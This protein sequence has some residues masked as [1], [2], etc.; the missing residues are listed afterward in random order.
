M[1]EFRIVSVAHT[2]IEIAEHGALLLHPNPMELL[3]L[4][5]SARRYLER[6]DPVSGEVRFG[7]DW[8]MVPC[9]RDDEEREAEVPP[10]DFDPE[11]S[12]VMETNRQTV[13][14]T[15]S[16]IRAHGFVGNSLSY[17]ESANVEPV[18]KDLADIQLR[19]RQCGS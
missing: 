11:E 4:A 16:S 12:F 14:I 9:D 13:V 17:F 7:Y 19:D 3:Q 6:V 18:L 10:D 1:S 8:G 5:A 2:D 15:M